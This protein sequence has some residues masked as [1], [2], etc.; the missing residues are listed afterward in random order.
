MTGDV[1][2]PR[3]FMTGVAQNPIAVSEDAGAVSAGSSR[4]AAFDQS[5]LG[6]HVSVVDLPESNGDA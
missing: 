1:A 2:A 6:P 3:E 4:V 5:V